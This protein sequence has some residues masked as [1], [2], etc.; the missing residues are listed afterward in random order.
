[1]D[2]PVA[3]FNLGAPAERVSTYNK[4]IL[5]DT[6]D[7]EAALNKIVGYYNEHLASRENP[8]KNVRVLFVGEYDSFSS[9]YR[10]EHFREQLLIQGISSD[11][12]NKKALKRVDP[13]QY[14]TVVIYRCR[15]TSITEA[16]IKAF[17]EHG[18]KVFYDIDDYIFSY[19]DIK[20]LD[21]LSGEDYKGFEKYSNEIRKC[22]ALCDGF[23]TSTTY[24]KQAIQ[25]AFPNAPVVINRNVASIEMAS[26][27]TTALN[28][29]RKSADRVVMGYFSGS[30]THDGDFGVI[31]DTV[32]TL[33]EKYD[34]LHLKIVGCLNLSDAFKEYEDRITHIDFVDWRE[35]PDL[36]ASADI[37]LMPIEDTF[38][39]RC[40]SE[41]KW[42][43]AALVATPTVCSYNKELE[44]IIQD[45][46]TGF[47]C[48]TEAQ[49]ESV[50][51][52]LIEE[53]DLR[54]KIGSAA[55][56]VAYKH[57]ITTGTGMEAI[58]FINQ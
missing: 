55:K 2:M 7:A 33:F 16:T 25:T 46:V 57:Y 52:R 42:M 30:K 22:M 56:N 4:R 31:A 9:R 44:P 32:L 21:F 5:I 38:F 35:L 36:I 49:W 10:V 53:P 58:D 18:K 1:M 11:Y 45:G 43:E 6:I 39:H 3:A 8:Y 12:V 17:H 50:L 24:M 19:D 15:H 34:F 13:R 20:D 29:I 26:L 14:N 51:T 37:N 54:M 41:N 27:S 40:K 48:R 47:L 28:K 23:I